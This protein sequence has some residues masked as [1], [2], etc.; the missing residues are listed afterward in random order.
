MKREFDTLET[1]LAIL[2]LNVLGGDLAA[3]REAQD[4]TDQGQAMEAKIEDIEDA[5]SWCRAHGAGT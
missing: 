4:L 1:E 2:L 5:I 3:Y